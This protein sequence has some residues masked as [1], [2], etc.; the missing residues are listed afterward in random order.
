MLYGLLVFRGAPASNVY[1]T[2]ILVYVHTR[3]KTTHK[4]CLM[5]IFF[6]PSVSIPSRLYSHSYENT[7]SY[8]LFMHNAC[9]QPYHI[10][11]NFPAEECLRHKLFFRG[12]IPQ[13]PCRR[14]ILP[15]FYYFIII[16][17]RASCDPK[18]RRKATMFYANEN[19]T[20]HFHSFARLKKRK[21][22]H[23]E[24]TL[25]ITLHLK[26]LMSRFL[27]SFA[28]IRISAIHVALTLGRKV[29]RSLDNAGYTY[30]LLKERETNTIRLFGKQRPKRNPPG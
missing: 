29:E 3:N 18:I 13:V 12:P 25:H 16:R 8:N 15:F 24:Q 19:G 20:C 14:K 1:I 27:V 23:G 2:Y 9:H 11:R 4:P 22:L 7:H 5:L 26:L 28:E 6:V 30:I 10:N 21:I 17:P